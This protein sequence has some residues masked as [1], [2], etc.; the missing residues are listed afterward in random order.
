MDDIELKIREVMN[1][2]LCDDLYKNIDDISRDENLFN[3]GLDSLNIV[4]LIMGIEEK[5][6][7]MFE[8]EE[9][10]SHNWKNISE[11]EKMI[12]NKI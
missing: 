7:I 2:E 8:N 12:K 10:A 11:I 6:N 9:I 3:V 1:D 4:K 5:F